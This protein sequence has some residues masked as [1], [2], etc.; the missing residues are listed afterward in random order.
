MANDK[1]LNENTAI[2]ECTDYTKWR[3]SFVDGIQTFDDLDQLLLKT[4]EKSR[5]GGSAESVM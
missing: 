2:P 3:R 5:Y 1:I 4:K